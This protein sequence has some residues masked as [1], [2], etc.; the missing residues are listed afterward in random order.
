MTKKL[1]Y[2]LGLDLGV[3]SVGWAIIRID[4]EN[5]VAVEHCGV[6]CFDSGTGVKSEIEQGKDEPRNFKRR[7]ARQ[8][9]RNQWRR[10]RRTLKLF[11]ILRNHNLL[12]IGNGIGDFPQQRQEII[13]HLDKQLAENFSL[14]DNRID[15]HLLPY[16]L[17]AFALDRELPPF[18]FGR[19]LLHLSQRRGFL[20][21]KKT[22]PKNEDEGQ[23]KKEISQL[24]NEI[25]EKG[26][27]TLGEYFA[28]LDPE[29]K[30]I[31]QRWT[32]RSMFIR[33]FN[34]IWKAQAA[35]NSNLTDELRKKIYGVLFFQ[36]PLKSKKGS[37]GK[38]ELEPQHRRAP[39][40]SAEAQKFRY[41]QKILDLKVQKP[42]GFLR[43]LSREEQDKL[44]DALEL[45]EK[46]TFSAIRKLLGLTKP[47]GAY[48]FNLETDGVKEI[49]GNS[50]STRI[51]EILKERWFS[52]DNETID[53]TEKSKNVASALPKTEKD[54]LISEILQFEHEDALTRRLEKRFKFDTNTASQLAAIRLE[55][56]YVKHSKTAINKLLDVMIDRRICYA[57]AKKEIYGKDD[58]NE[59]TFEFLPQILKS[60]NKKNLNNADIPFFKDDLR[61]PIVL[62]TLTEVRKVVNAVIRKYGKPKMIRVELA[63]D[64]KKSRSERDMDNKKNHANEA[65]REAAR[66]QI[67]KETGNIEPKPIEIKKIILAEECN[68][69]CPYTGKQI[70]VVNLLGAEP[71]FDID[72]ILPFS[73]SLDD[74]YTNKT[75]CEIHENRHVKKN[76]TPFEAYGGDP[77]RWHE[78][79]TRVS[80]FRGT[81]ASI[82]LQRFKM[83]TIPDNF[84]S[85]MLNDTRYISRL[86]GDYLGLLYGG[87]VDAD[88]KLRIQ[89]SSG[90]MTA[91]LRGEWKLNAILADG[92]DRKNRTDHRHH[93]IDAVVIALNNM[94]TVKKLSEAA[95]RASD[96]HLHR[97]FVKGGIELPMENFVAQVRAAISNINI[98]FRANR[99]VS[100]GFHD[101]TNYSPPI[102]GF[103]KIGK[104]VEYRHIRKPLQNMSKDEIENIVDPSIKRL[105]KE[106]LERLGGD[107]R[108]FTEEELPYISTK[109]GRIIPIRKARIRKVIGTM[110]LAPTTAKERHVAPGTNHH[111]EIFEV[112]DDSGNVKKLDWR[113]VNLFEAVQ[114][115]KL[116]RRVIADS[117]HYGDGTPTQLKFSLAKGEYVRATLPNEDT[118]L[119]RVCKIS[120]GDIS[121][122]LHTDARIESL[123][124]EKNSKDQ[125]SDFQKYRITSIK[126]L[127]QFKLHKVTVDLLGCIHPAND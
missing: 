101:D 98:S 67:I 51:G 52:V 108:K 111:I 39:A 37:I 64:M 9:R 68:W 115:V 78:I 80:N 69:E 63:R 83:E 102:K 53:E 7:S 112:F 11:N 103:N 30:R 44:A 118:V 95:E 10:K 2:I 41:W 49:R 62:R 61:N 8:I 48:R 55:D 91:Y 100:G 50:T 85:R 21:N 113:C 17:R 87:K 27:R 1:E 89:T 82:K 120:D 34:E 114:R 60:L 25:N 93:A 13:N 124:K 14:L 92:G 99:R 73:R 45:S 24:Q 72:H 71:Q 122:C 59:A 16:K 4:D 81:H 3:Q 58:A 117:N 116:K 54:A 90:G 38:C 32:G 57:T 29:E 88:G 70:T 127:N 96:M 26:F 33:E 65:K 109:S 126:K 28:S 123:R 66:S 47:K 56:G 6:R 36:R 5:P 105:V 18:A 79:L 22:A 46:Q 20:S 125:Q 15:A 110:T 19:V 74:S 84:P 97:L 106:K 121:L 35:L 76:Q 75:L 31:R 12:P 107:T 94:G 86:A 119:L 77:Q 43:D 23:I 104:Q 42:D 40:A